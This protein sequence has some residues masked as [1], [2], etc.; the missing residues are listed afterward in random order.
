M[1]D[2]NSAELNKL[3]SEY[4]GMMKELAESTS[5]LQQ[6]EHQRKSLEVN[7]KQN[8]SQLE[9]SESRCILCTFSLCLI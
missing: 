2:R 5:K 3:R 9:V 6:E 4:G 7:Y 1:P 8:V